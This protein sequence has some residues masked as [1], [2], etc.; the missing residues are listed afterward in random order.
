MSCP[1][2]YRHNAYGIQHN[3]HAGR[4]GGWP[5]K[6][7]APAVRNRPSSAPGHS[8]S[9][10]VDLRQIWD[11]QADARYDIA[12]NRTE[13]LMITI[14]THSG[15]GELSLAGQP[16][17]TLA[18]DSLITVEQS[19]IR[20]YRS[21][22]ASWDFWWFEYTLSDVLPVAGGTA[23]WV[24]GHPADAAMFAEI[25]VN[26]QHPA[27]AVRH[28]ASAAFSLMLHRWVAEIRMRAVLS[29]YQRVIEQVIDRIR[30]T[31]SDDWPV[32]RLASEAGMGETLFRREFKRVAGVAPARFIRQ[33]RLHAAVLMIQQGIYSLA[34]IASQLNFSSAFHLSTAFKQEYG[35]SPS[36][37]R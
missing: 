16:P 29:P 22:E 21:V 12:C 2:E 30:Q 23:F 13:R 33:A 8:R 6:D 1:Y 37:W 20:R 14:R 36:Q 31:L 10:V 28:I 3:A 4:E 18:A 11:V 27:P 25:F 26:L 24:S 35:V 5:V 34:G 32:S 19:R 17:V 9:L 7:E 15:A